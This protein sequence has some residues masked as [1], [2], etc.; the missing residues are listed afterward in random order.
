MYAL[1]QGL[2]DTVVALQAS[3]LMGTFTLLDSTERA[4]QRHQALHAS[5]ALQGRIASLRSA[6]AKA[7]QMAR[8]VET[9]LQIRKL[10]AELKQLMG[11]L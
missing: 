1:Y 2:L 6:V 3:A 7:S 10:E 8:Q 5:I 11:A 9:N 4:L